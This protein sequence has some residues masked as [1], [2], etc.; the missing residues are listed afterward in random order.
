MDQN[1][2]TQN[3]LRREGSQNND[4]LKHL[5]S[6]AALKLNFDKKVKFADQLSFKLDNPPLFQSEELQPIEFSNNLKSQVKQGQS[7][8]KGKKGKKGSKKT[9]RLFEPPFMK[10]RPSSAKKQPI[11]TSGWNDNTR[12][13]KYFDKNIDPKAKKE[14]DKLVRENAIG[15]NRPDSATGNNLVVE[16]NL[17]NGKY[18]VGFLK[19]NGQVGSKF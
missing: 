1:R 3:N 14:Y 16:K 17:E 6:N 2:N 7:K 11:D 18:E 13:A 4:D 15:A 10:Q 12:T 19:S 9:N 5:V 8:G